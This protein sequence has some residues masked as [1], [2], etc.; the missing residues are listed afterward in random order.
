MDQHIKRIAFG[1]A[2]VVMLGAGMVT[3]R[4]VFAQEATPDASA[5]P[6]VGG[7]STTEKD[8]SDTDK[9]GKGDRDK[10]EGGGRHDGMRGAG[11]MGRGLHVDRAALATFLG[12]TEDELDTQLR[13]GSSILEITEA[14][15][16]T[17]TELETFLIDQYT[18][19]ITEVLDGIAADDAGTTT[20]TP[21]VGGEDATGTPAAGSQN[22]F[23]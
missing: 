7:E 16:K 5:T 19:H 14:A 8:T 9:P 10:R 15:G 4:G 12:I 3:A 11:G 17:R 6:A 21:A 13:S 23:L 20:E 1:L 2:L 18:T 22:T